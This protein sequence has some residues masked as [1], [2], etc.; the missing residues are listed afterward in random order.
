MAIDYLATDPRQANLR[1]LRQYIT[2]LSM[3]AM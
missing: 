3:E 1:K 2:P